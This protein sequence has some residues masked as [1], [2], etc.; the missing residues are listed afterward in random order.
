M[1]TIHTAMLWR[2]W[3]RFAT[4]EEVANVALLLAS[5]EFSYV[6]GVELFADGAPAQV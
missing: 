5:D 2:P 4:P 6:T 3:E 1:T